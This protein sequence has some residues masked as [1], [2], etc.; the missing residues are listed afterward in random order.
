[1]LL[2]LAPPTI[3]AHQYCVFLGIMFAETVYLTTSRTFGNTMEMCG[4][5]LR[6]LF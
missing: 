6:I 1:M 3:V 2:P 5:T 4:C